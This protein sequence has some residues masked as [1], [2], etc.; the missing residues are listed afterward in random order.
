MSAKKKAPDEHPKPFNPNIT[1]NR[2]ILDV[3]LHY[4]SRAV[5]KGPASSQA[6][7]TMT[8]QRERL[9]GGKTGEDFHSQFNA[10]WKTGGQWLDFWE[11][12]MTDLDSTGN[13]ALVTAMFCKWCEMAGFKHNNR[14][15]PEKFC[16]ECGAESSPARL[17]LPA[18][19]RDRA[20][21]VRTGSGPMPMCCDIFAAGQLWRGSL[22]TTGQLS[23]LLPIVVCV[24][25]GWKV[26][27][28][29]HCSNHHCAPGDSYAEHAVPDGAHYSH[30][31]AVVGRRPQHELAAHLQ[32]GWSLPCYT[33][34]RCLAAALG[35][36]AQAQAVLLVLGDRLQRVARAQ[37]LQ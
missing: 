22:L 5:L 31:V 15:K 2:V 1:L 16:S 8:V 20:W 35:G 30:G 12:T 34:H 6:L 18:A 17:W 9:K 10:G 11:V 33:P 4:N 26:E 32:V 7:K 14:G 37:A 29:G 25:H 27:V 3:L 28:T 23:C 19:D 21:A 36:R 13:S 24:G